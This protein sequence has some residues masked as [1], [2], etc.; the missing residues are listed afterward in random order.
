ML[1]KLQNIFYALL[2]ASLSLAFTGLMLVYILFGTGIQTAQNQ[3]ESAEVAV[4]Q[5]FQMQINNRFSQALEGI[6]EVKKIY[7]LSDDDLV[8]PKPDQDNFGTTD[9]PSTLGWLLEDAKELL[10]G[11]TTLFSTDAVLPAGTAVNYYLDETL[12]AV[13]W[14]QAIKDTMYTISE[15]KIAHPSQ[16]RRFLSGG[17]FGSG[18][19][20]KASETASSVNA[21]VASSGD[22]Y[23]HR[24][25]G[26][27]V[28]N[29]TVHRVKSEYLDTCYI[30]ENGDMLFSYRKQLKDVAEAQQFVDENNIR[31]SLAFGPTLINDGQKRRLDVYAIGDI[32]EPHCRAALCQMGPLHYVLVTASL[33]NECN[34]L[35]DILTFQDVLL[36]FGCEKA[37]N[38][39]GGQ[40][41][42]IVMNDTVINRVS[43]NEERD[44]S[45]IIYFATALPNH[46]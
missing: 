31:F 17:A 45:D 2:V 18:I 7:W 43:Y 46:E 9:D 8:A 34:E 33:E 21:V 1:K 25:M 41:A 37:Y 35:V 20:L 44:V 38:L 14:K 23:A 6:L 16:F 11:Q 32:Y 36:S 12:F 29:G 19:Q 26:I 4:A 39:D 3:K 42:V 27:S 40:T 22:F 15:V 13:T 5:R 10:D 28:Y 24:R 30:D